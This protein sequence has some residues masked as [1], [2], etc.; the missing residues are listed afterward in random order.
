MNYIHKLQKEIED[1]KVQIE[2]RKMVEI[3]LRS[4]L[5]LAKFKDDTTVQVS[6]I[7]HRLDNYDFYLN[8]GSDV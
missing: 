5:D 6:D 4:Y 3:E 7:Y 2:A 1:L 8:E